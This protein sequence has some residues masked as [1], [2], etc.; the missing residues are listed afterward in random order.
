MNGRR[1]TRREFFRLSATMAAGALAAACA[2]GTMAPAMPAPAT[3]APP[4]LAPR[5][6]YQVL[7][8]MLDKAGPPGVEMRRH[9][10]PEED[11]PCLIWLMEKYTG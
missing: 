10:S 5:D 1:M 6:R 2:P 11:P 3:P 8:G 4:A 7:K 9:F